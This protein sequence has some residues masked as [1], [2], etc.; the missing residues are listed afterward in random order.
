MLSCGKAEDKGTEAQSTAVSVTIKGYCLCHWQKE[1]EELMK[2]N[3]DVS[4][5]VVGGG[6]GVGITA[7]IDGTTDIAMASR[8][9][10]TEENEI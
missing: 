2:T 7:M 8:D 10:K 6:S 9:L 1:A 5:T 3:S 4:V